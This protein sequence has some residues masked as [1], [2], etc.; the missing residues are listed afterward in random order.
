MHST[1]YDRTPS[2]CELDDVLQ[3]LDIRDDG[4]C[5]MDGSVDPCLKQ[6]FYGTPSLFC[7]LEE[8]SDA[9]DPFVYDPLMFTPSSSAPSSKPPTPSG[10]SFLCLA[11]R[12][13]PSRSSLSPGD[14]RIRVLFSVASTA[15]ASNSV[16]ENGEA[17]TQKALVGA[18]ANPAA[19]LTDTF[20]AVHTAVKSVIHV[21]PTIVASYISL[22]LG[23]TTASKVSPPVG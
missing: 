10:G 11:D 1:I 19:I 17:E 21:D 4:N 16:L 14:T 8:E 13:K 18:S 5:W 3:Q 15:L 22:T 6:P 23:C 7:A 9:C 12:D 20:P 2:R